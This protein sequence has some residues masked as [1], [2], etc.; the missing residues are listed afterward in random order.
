[1]KKS[2]L[3]ILFFFLLGNSTLLWAQTDQEEVKMESNKFQDYFYEALK[4]KAIENYDK[5]IVALEQCLKI[6]PENATIHFELGKN[7]L[8]L[9]EYKNAYNSLEHATQIDSTNKWFWIGMY[10]VSYETKDYNQAIITILKLI[11]FDAKFKED[12]TSL[13]MNTNQFDKALDLINELNETSG[14]SDL[15]NSYKMQILSQGK[16][17]NAEIANLIEQIKKYPKEEFNYISLIYLYS[18]NNEVEKVLETTRKLEEEI[19]TSEWAQ[20]TLFK[21]YLDNNEGEKAVKAMNIVLTSTKIDTNIKH[22]ILNEFLLFVN[23]N[24][25]FSSD[26]DKAI[27][28]FDNDPD[29]NVSKEIG[30]FYHNRKQMDLAIK[31]YEQSNAKNATADS[32]TNL[33]LLQAYTEI[34]EFE[35][36]SKNAM[37]CID[38]FPSQPQFYYYAGLGY[39]QLSQF[40]KAKEILEMGL[41]YLVEDIKLEINFNIQLGEAYNGLGDFKKKDFY[42]S[43]ANQLLKQ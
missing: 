15:R 9:K 43:K 13:Y 30:K 31:Y 40:K 3:L 20:V 34:R 8:A 28:Y 10:D 42:F 41:D 25:Q 19:P 27:G 35:L 4:Q 33:L 12:L 17:Q 23:T 24:Q 21:K 26:L 14:K 38:I 6:E 22:R 7:Y 18:K 16:Y 36:V 29:V 32:E 11:S 2:I 1:M 39:N 37:E 5:A